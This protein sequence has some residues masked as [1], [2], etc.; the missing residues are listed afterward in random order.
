MLTVTI[1]FDDDDDEWRKITPTFHVLS[2]FIFALGL[3]KNH[4]MLKSMFCVF[5][6]SLTRAAHQLSSQRSCR[7][8]GA[9]QI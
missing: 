7:F 8:T 9:A 1:S 6:K 5:Q 3:L 4:V 2:L